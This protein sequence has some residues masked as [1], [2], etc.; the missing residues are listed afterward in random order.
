VYDVRHDHDALQRQVTHQGIAKGFD[1]CRANYPLRREF[2]TL[3]VFLEN[4]AVSLQPSLQAAGF[5][6]RCG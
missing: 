6:V 4:D 1:S 5:Q 2:A 3:T